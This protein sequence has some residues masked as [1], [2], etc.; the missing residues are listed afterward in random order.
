LRKVEA[1]ELN[2]WH[3]VNIAELTHQRVTYGDV[4]RYLA[5]LAAI[6]DPVAVAVCVLA[7]QFGIDGSDRCRCHSRQS[8]I[9][10]CWPS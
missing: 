2:A 6:P 3:I 7:A 8:G 9:C 5:Q 10:P 4:G 1:V